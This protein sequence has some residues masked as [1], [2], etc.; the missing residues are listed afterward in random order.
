MLRIQDIVSR[1]YISD[2]LSQM[3]TIHEPF[4]LLCEAAPSECISEEKWRVSYT[5]EIEALIT[6]FAPFRI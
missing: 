5:E 6:K 2:D 1:Y 3:R 4:E